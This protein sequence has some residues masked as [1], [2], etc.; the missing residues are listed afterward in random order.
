MKRREIL[1][2]SLLLTIF[3]LLVT[4]AFSKGNLET[5]QQLQLGHTVVHMTSETNILPHLLTM[6]TAQQKTAAR[7][8]F[9]VQLTDEKYMVNVESL[10]GQKPLHILAP[11]LFALYVE[12]TGSWARNNLL[13][14]PG[15][16]LRGMI[17]WMGHLKPE[18]KTSLNFDLVMRL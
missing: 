9:L 13:P 14:V 16:R 17:Q 6:A 8:L 12:N 18:Y 1:V 10:L 11:T 3:L 15:R 7:G 2:Q 4:T 5:L